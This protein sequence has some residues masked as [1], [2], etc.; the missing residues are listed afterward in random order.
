M[1]IAYCTCQTAITTD[2]IFMYAS[3]AWNTKLNIGPRKLSLEEHSCC[4][5][6]FGVHAFD[7]TKKESSLILSRPFRGT[8]WYINT[9]SFVVQIILYITVLAIVVDQLDVPAPGEVQGQQCLLDPAPNNMS[10]C[11]YV[12]AMTGIGMFFSLLC[13]A[14]MVCR[15]DDGLC[16]VS[17]LLLEVDQSSCYCFFLLPSIDKV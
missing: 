13:S 2:F 6:M 15:V 9:V 12:Y 10:L 7:E 17:I 14:I 4:C 5:C 16:C 3:D 1:G 11:L 8:V